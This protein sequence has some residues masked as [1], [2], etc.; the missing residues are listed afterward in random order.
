[1]VKSTCY[2]SRGL[3]FSSNMYIKAVHNHLSLQLQGACEPNIN[4]KSNK[5]FKQVG[6]MN[7]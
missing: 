3:K 4:E 2:S 6:V 5:S 1:M 7:Q